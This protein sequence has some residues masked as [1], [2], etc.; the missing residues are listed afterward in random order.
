M[1]V[2]GVD[3]E[4]NKLD[5]LEAQLAG[6]L[7]PAEKDFLLSMVRKYIDLGECSEGYHPK[8]IIA[9]HAGL[10]YSGRIA[11][12]A[13]GGWRDSIGN[14]E[15]IILM[16]GSGVYDFPGVAIP[17]SKAI[18]TPLGVA[19][20]DGEAIGQ[21]L[22]HRFVR[23]FEAPFL[24]EPGIELQLPFIQAVFP[25]VK[26]VPMIVGRCESALIC[27]LIAELWGGVETKF[28]ISSNLST[29]KSAAAAEIHNEQVALTM[30][31]MDGSSIK[32][33]DAVGFRVVKPFLKV[34][35]RKKLFCVCTV[36]E[37]VSVT[38]NSVTSTEGYGAFQFAEERTV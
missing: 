27:N 28:V 18:K 6:K 13:Y 14:T 38:D 10:A 2:L 25:A 24:G 15:R 33:G 11:G 17:D 31:E 12:E 8:A 23:R 37:N 29:K 32:S 26:I 19:Y 36:V 1:M 22:K 4:E 20:F 16:A 35:R 3:Q 34:A 9:P 5:L 7:Y 30:G 21:I